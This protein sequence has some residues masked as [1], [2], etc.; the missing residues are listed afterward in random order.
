M[1]IVFLPRKEMDLLGIDDEALAGAHVMLERRQRERR[2]KPDPQVVGHR[3]S[4]RR[5]T[6][7][8]TVS[9]VRMADVK[10]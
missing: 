1:L 2:A 9:L 10:E 7:P 3:A 5:R 8:W 4:K 6:V